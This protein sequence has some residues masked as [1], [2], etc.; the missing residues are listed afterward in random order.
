MAVY[1][2]EAYKLAG[3]AAMTLIGTKDSKELTNEEMI[4]WAHELVSLADESLAKEEEAAGK[5]EL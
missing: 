1:R 4:D 3:I 2:D 5:N